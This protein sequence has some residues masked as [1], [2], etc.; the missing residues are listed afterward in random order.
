MVPE[1]DHLVIGNFAT[2]PAAV[3]LIEESDVLLSVGT[4]FRSNETQHYSLKLPA[5]HIQLDLNP[6]AV[7]R[8][9]PATVGLVGDSREI[10]E[11]IVG[12]LGSH[13]VDAAWAQQVHDVRLEVRATLTEYIGGYAEICHSLRERLDR[14]SVVARDV[15]IPSSQWGGNR[16]LEM[17]SRETNIFPLG[18]GI[19]QGLAMGIGGSLR[20]PGRSHGSYCRRRR[21]G[22]SSW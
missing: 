10:L 16:L 5:T 14:E 17:Y 8:V 13:S 7:G 18:G 4:H 20:P 9:Y 1:D 11:A 3:R 19:G 21:P 6:E 2:T 15:T 12:Q 22:R